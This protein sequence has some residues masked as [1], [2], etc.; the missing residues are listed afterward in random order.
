MTGIFLPQPRGWW[1]GIW[2]ITG[3][4]IHIRVEVWG[5]VDDRVSREGGYVQYGAGMVDIWEQRAEDGGSP[6]SRSDK[7]LRA[8][9]SNAGIQLDCT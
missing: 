3:G 4:G 6:H 8:R 1:W 5:A 9:D 7:D 2:C